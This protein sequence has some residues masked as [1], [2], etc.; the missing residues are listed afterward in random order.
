MSVLRIRCVNLH[1]MI[2]WYK[3][4][5][6]CVQCDLNSLDFLF[7]GMNVN[8]IVTVINLTQSYYICNCEDRIN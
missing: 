6:I 4:D 8:E 7:G 5:W 2:W 3:Y 1:H